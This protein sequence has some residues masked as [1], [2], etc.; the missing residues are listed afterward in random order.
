MP[1]PQQIGIYTIEAHVGEWNLAEVYKAF[2]PALKRTVTLK[3]LRA[4]ALPKGVSTRMFLDRAQSAIELVHPHLAWLWE[5][6]E[7]EG[8]CFLVERYVEGQRLDQ[9]LSSS[10]AL[11]WQAAEAVLQQ[12]AKGLEFAHSRGYAHGD[13]RP[14]NILISP[15]LGAVLTDFGLAIALQ[16][17]MSA[18][19]YRSPELSAGRFPSPASDQYALACVLMEMLT[20]GKPPE[21][22]SAEEI[23]SWHLQNLNS[24]E[25]LPRAIPWQAIPAIRRALARDPGQRFPTIGE[26]AGEP[27]RLV[28]GGGHERQQYEAA[29]ESLRQAE[30]EA[31]RQAEEA[32]RLEALERA[33]IEMQ[34]ELA[35]SSKW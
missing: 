31:R 18:S 28:I 27:A 33:R 5:T 7:A 1:I 2:D 24:L 14:G 29:A 8:L 25:S 35:R 20:G 30:E 23:H 12:V 13:I 6:G 19:Q 15:E 4:E 11:E 10:D 3:V 22:G 32:S 16:G 9:M 17:G 21:G 26:F 34:E